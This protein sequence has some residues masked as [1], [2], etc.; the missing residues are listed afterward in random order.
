MLAAG[1]ECFVPI[2]Q[3]IAFTYN[4]TIGDSTYTLTNLGL[5]IWM[6]VYQPTD[7]EVPLKAL[8][9]S[10]LF[11]RT[12]A[13]LAQTRKTETYLAVVLEG[14]GTSRAYHYKRVDLVHVELPS[15]IVI[16]REPIEIFLA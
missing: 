3:N 5:R 6:R 10:K 9:N 15:S 8:L 2:N 11:G 14:T 16:T 4:A 7:S 13:I 1:P 12:F